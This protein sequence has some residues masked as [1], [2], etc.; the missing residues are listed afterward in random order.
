MIYLN[1]IVIFFQ[2]LF[3]K[4][5]TFMLVGHSFSFNPLFSGSLAT[6]LQLKFLMLKEVNTLLQCP[7]KKVNAQRAGATSRKK[8]LFA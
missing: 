6:V 2:D 3:V 4:N 5:R 8:W 1:S 7:G